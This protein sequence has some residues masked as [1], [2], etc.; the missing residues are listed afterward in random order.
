MNHCKYIVLQE[1]NTKNFN[2]LSLKNE[3]EKLNLDLERMRKALLKLNYPC[4]NIPA[5]QI[6]G[7]NGKGSISA[8][9]EN[10]LN[11]A[12]INIGVTTSPHLMDIT[13]RIRVNQI[14]IP[15]ENFAMLLKNIQNI[16]QEFDLTPFELIICCGLKYFDLKKVQLLILEAGLGGRLD[17]TTAHKF[18]PI[19]AFGNIGIDHTEYLGD[20]LEKITK[21]KAAVIEKESFVISCYQ[22][23][24]VRKIINDRV[25]KVGAFIHWVE[26]LSEDW[27][28]G[29]KGNFQRQNASVALKVAH[30]LIKKGW[31]IK[32]KDIKEGLAKTIW[33]GRLEVINYENKSILVDSAH[34]SSAA[35]VLSSERRNWNNQEKGVYWI[36]G[37]QKQKNIVAIIQKLIKSIDKVLIVPVPNQESWSLSEIKKLYKYK[38]ENFIEF[39]NFIDALIYLKGLD[40]WPKCMPV[41]T[42]SIFLVSEFIKYSKS[43]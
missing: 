30:L 8:F 3:R 16:V 9:L 39:N 28:L 32:N 36:I 6:V 43:N 26:P 27:E 33:S 1:I 12:K 13:E 38:L 34:N 23:T 5:I 41:I 4:H 42:G 22:S 29:L 20:T 18:R 2:F 37:V 7:T 10:I 15:T 14:K 11:K 24:I 25:K 19:I 21:E 40:E 31:P 35:E 17:A